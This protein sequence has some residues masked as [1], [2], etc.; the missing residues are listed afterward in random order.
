MAYCWNPTCRRTRVAM[1]DIRN[2][3][4]MS[5]HTGPPHVEWPKSAGP[6]RTAPRECIRLAQEE[7]NKAWCA[8]SYYEAMAWV[9]SSVDW[10]RRGLEQMAPDTVA[11][12]ERESS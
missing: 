1:E 10:L 3:G 2:G 11:L 12:T 7:M 9:R 8:D 4:R 6:D 5:E